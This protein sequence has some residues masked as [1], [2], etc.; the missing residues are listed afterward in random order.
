MEPNR[1]LGNHD[2]LLPGCGGRHFQGY[3][4]MGVASAA[5]SNGRV[6]WEREFVRWREGPSK[7]SV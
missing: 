2:R 4:S 5:A 7:R 6:A 1:S 3:Q